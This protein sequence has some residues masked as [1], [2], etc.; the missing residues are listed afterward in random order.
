MRHRRFDLRRVAAIL[1]PVIILL[2]AGTEGAGVRPAP[3]YAQ[4][5]DLSQMQNDAHNASY[6]SGRIEKR[7]REVR[8]LV[9]VTLGLTVIGLGLGGYLLLRPGTVRRDSRSGAA[10]GAAL[11]PAADVILRWWRDNRLGSLRR[12]QRRLA[13]A[14]AELQDVAELATRRN[15]EMS[16]LLASVKARMEELDEGLEKRPTDVP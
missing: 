3:A 16:V 9:Y 5:A 4:E 6:M 15:Q 8:T 12:R 2:L 10:L 14:V 13:R 11:G 1:A 7:V